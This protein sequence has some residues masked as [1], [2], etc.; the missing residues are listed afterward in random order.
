MDFK[1]GE[2]HWRSS[3]SDFSCGRDHYLICMICRS[4]KV[5]REFALAPP[6]PSMFDSACLPSLGPLMGD[7]LAALGFI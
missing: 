5:Y 7:W 3:P 1:V 6:R 4:F 2:H